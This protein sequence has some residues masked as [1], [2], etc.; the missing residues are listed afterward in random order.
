MAIT[1][2][3]ASRRLDAAYSIMNKTG[4]VNIDGPVSIGIDLGTADV[5]LMVLDLSLIHI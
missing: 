5:V 3:E 4:A 2:E 1:W